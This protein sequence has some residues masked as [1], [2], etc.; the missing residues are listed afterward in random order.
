MLDD[1][2]RRFLALAVGLT[3]VGLIA[4]ADMPVFRFM[5]V[6][7]SHACLMD[8]MIFLPEQVDFVALGSS[9][10]RRGISPEIISEHSDG[11]LGYGI[12]LGKPRR[13]ILRSESV[14]DFL[15]DKGRVP[16]VVILEANLESIR[17]GEF[18]NWTWDELEASFITYEQILTGLPEPLSNEL[19]LKARGVYL[20]LE[21]SLIRHLT[22][23]TWKTIEESS[24]EAP[25]MCI[26]PFHDAMN[27][28][29]AVRGRDRAL[30]TVTQT[31]ENPETDFDDRFVKDLT[32]TGLIELRAIDQ[33]REKLQANGVEM[34]VVRTQA[35]AD[36][37]LSDEVIERIQAYIPEFRTPRGEFARELNML[38]VDQTHLGA[39]GRDMYSKWLAEQI[40][41][42][43]GES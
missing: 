3:G 6:G 34:I 19:R 16:K 2:F 23:R 17:L 10:I 21:Q 41:E 7:N 1:I 33:I 39:E 5:S 40:L 18:P 30:R 14:I 27:S 20:K 37:P 11:Y 8:Q 9:R 26:R 29:R 36:P 32:E 42:M 43:R 4:A 31:F 22:E 13:Q 28:T 15:L 12:N 38:G 25:T 35:F 24:G